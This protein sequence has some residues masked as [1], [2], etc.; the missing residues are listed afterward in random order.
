M[1]SEPT[2]TLG[3]STAI[4]VTF[5]LQVLSCLL[6]RFEIDVT[7]GTDCVDGCNS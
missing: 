4:A 3:E 6:T 2:D 1:V 7:W 5:P